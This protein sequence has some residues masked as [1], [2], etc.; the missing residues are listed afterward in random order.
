M[1]RIIVLDS[2]P[3]GLLFHRAGLREADDCRAWLE[4]HLAAGGRVIV[5]EVVLYELRRELLRLNKAA[6][7][8][9]LDTFVNLVP[10]R[11]LPINSAAMSLAAELWARARQQGLPTAPAQALDIDVILS[12]QVLSAGLARDFVVATSNVAHLSRFVPAELWQNI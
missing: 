9:A 11:L 1:I 7:L 12:A 2:T 6:A 10:D 5:P 4:R 3:L 8:A